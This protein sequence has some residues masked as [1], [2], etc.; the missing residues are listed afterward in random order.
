MLDIFR[1]A[2]ATKIP[3][4]R[5]IVDN[6]ICAL[7]LERML[8][9]FPATSEISLCS[10]AWIDDKGE[11]FFPRHNIIEHRIFRE[12]EFITNVSLHDFQGE[13]KMSD[14]DPFPEFLWSSIPVLQHRILQIYLYICMYVYVYVSFR[15]CII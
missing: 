10:I 5:L 13:S 1:N 12:K 2:V 7:D 14:D 4:W 11:H 8:L 15:S 3:S 9:V 6:Q